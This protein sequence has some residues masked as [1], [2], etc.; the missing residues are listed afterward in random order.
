MTSRNVEVVCID[1]LKAPCVLT[2][3]SD[4]PSSLGSM[5]FTPSDLELDHCRDSPG[6]ALLCDKKSLRKLD[7][8]SESMV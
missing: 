2:P 1:H 3:Q 4:P 7:Q 5:Q 6:T 8:S